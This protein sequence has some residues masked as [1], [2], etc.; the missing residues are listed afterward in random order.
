MGSKITG[1]AFKLQ[2][3]PKL[4]CRWLEGSVKTNVRYPMPFWLLAELHLLVV[5]FFGFLFIFFM[6]YQWDQNMEYSFKKQVA[7]AA[8]EYCARAQVQC[9]P[10]QSRWVFLFL[11]VCKARMNSEKT[12]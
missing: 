11:Y 12:Y 6:I 10:N 3:I 9:Y 5:Y 1:K 7:A 2:E 8:T 4:L